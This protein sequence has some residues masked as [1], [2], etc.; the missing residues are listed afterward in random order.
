[1]EWAGPKSEIERRYVAMVRR[2]VRALEAGR[3]SMQN[4]TGPPQSATTEKRN[5]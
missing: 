4:W 1:M 5:L 2:F 3:R